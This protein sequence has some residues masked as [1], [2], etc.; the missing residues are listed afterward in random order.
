MQQNSAA[1]SMIQRAGG[2]KEL[3]ADRQ[4][5]FESLNESEPQ[6]GVLELLASSQQSNNNEID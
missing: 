6:E 5:H 4:A 3:P 2:V 1:T